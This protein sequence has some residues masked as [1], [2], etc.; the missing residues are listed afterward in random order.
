[1]STEPEWESILGHLDNLEDW[2]RITELREAAA[3][4]LVGSTVDPLNVL[5]DPQREEPYD[6][7]HS[8]VDPL[9]PA[10]L[11]AKQWEALGRQERFRWLFWANQSGKTTLGAIDTALL[12]LGRHPNQQWEP[13]L[14]IWASALTWN[15]WE[16]ILLP[17][18]LTWI[19]PDRLIDYPEPRQVSTKRTILVRADNGR[20]SR[21]VGK[22]AEQGASKYQSA[23]VHHV[24]MDEEHPEPVYDEIQPRL[25]RHHGT[26]LTTATPLLGLTWIYH[27]IYVPWKRGQSRIHFCSHAGLAD[28][29]A[30]T[31][32]AV[33]Q[34][35]KEFENDPAQ[36]AAR[37]YGHF[38]IPSGIALLF[39]PERHLVDFGPERRK[40]AAEEKWRHIC[41]VDFGYWRFAFVHGVVDPEARCTIVGEIF[42]QKEDLKRRAE[43]IDEHLSDWGAPAST[44]LWGDA[45]NPT[46]IVELNRELALIGSPYRVRPVRAENKARRASITLLNNLLG[47]ESMFVS[48]SV[49]SEQHW[50]LGQSAA[51]EG[52]P[53]IG[54]R[55]LY[56]AGQWRYPKPKEG[57]A[58]KQDPDDH[59]ADGADMIAAWRYMTMSHYG[60][61]EEKV[62][63]EVKRKNF[64]YGLE[65]MNK[66]VAG[67]DWD[68]L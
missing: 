24:W 51:T 27:R 46:D 54:S 14:L 57:E 18:L 41:G 45:A 16:N 53:Q 62:E 58:Q 4:I 12:A 68:P 21:I 50:R 65:E 2:V 59:T 63:V 17:E 49:A 25:L 47:R 67:A 60:P 42:S 20:V 52:R 15:L 61:L 38:A 1:M 56:E 10:N 34:I 30:I 23:R 39:D 64:D 35:T 66:R 5:F 29:P 19:P 32:E 6:Y 55:L 22:S 3:N 11:H 28:N 13:P 43:R 26:T 9:I 36:A 40:I 37:L 48:K 31:P 33:E 44:R 7:E 8:R